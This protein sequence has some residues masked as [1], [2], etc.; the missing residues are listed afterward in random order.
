MRI[1]IAAP[2]NGTELKNALKARLQTDPRVSRLT[3]LSTPDGTYPQLS[4]AAAQEVA[5]GRADRAIL[6]CGTGV[7]TAIAANKVRGIRAATAHDLVTVRGSVENYDA[8]VL[9]MGQNVIAAP[10]AWALV[11][12]WLDLRHDTSSG[13]APK[14]GEIDAFERGA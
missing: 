4:F 3:D 8:Q 6:I 7:G 13:Y 5:A 12:I 11:D 1:V 9:C 10:A 14:V 2:S